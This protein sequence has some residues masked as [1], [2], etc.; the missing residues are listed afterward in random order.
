MRASPVIAL[1][2]L[3]RKNQFRIG[4]DAA[5][6]QKSPRSSSRPLVIRPAW[7][8]T[9]CHCSSSSIVCTADREIFCPCNRRTLRRFH[10]SRGDR[11][12]ADFEHAA[13]RFNGVPSQSAIRIKVCF[14]LE[15]LLLAIC[16]SLS[17]ERIHTKS[18][19]VNKNICIF[20]QPMK[21]HGGK[22]KG[23]GRPSE[24][25]AVHVTLTEDNVKQVK[26]RKEKLSPLLDGMLA[27]WLA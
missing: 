21:Q 23:A 26:K 22:R 24:G 18:N 6:S 3:V 11:Y 1:S 4:V 17:P 8:P 9:Y 27:R 2:D 20:F 16:L 10:G 7:Q 19:W 25:K 12:S 14:S 13:A 15:S 5:H